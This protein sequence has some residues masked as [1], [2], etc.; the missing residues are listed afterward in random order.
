MKKLT[1]V[2]DNA[3]L[4]LRMD[5]WNYIPYKIRNGAVIYD[6]TGNFIM[7]ST[8]FKYDNA[9]ERPVLY[10]FD[11]EEECVEWCDKNNKT[12]KIEL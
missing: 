9:G 8:K 4:A 12:M 6:T 7:P 5:R 11:S 10:V 3:I 1:R 2:P